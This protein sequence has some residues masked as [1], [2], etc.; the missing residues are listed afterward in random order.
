MAKT[1]YFDFIGSVYEF[2]PDSD[3]KILLETWIGYEQ[4]FASVYQKFLEADLNI[5]IRDLQ[6]YATERWINFAFDDSNFIPRQAFLTSTQDISYGIN[7]TNRYLLRF[8]VD[9]GAAFEVDIRGKDRLSTKIEEIVKKINLVAGF[10]FCRAIYD[11]SILQVSSQTIGPASKVEIL[12]TSDMSKNA[13]E[14]TFGLDPDSEDIP[15]LYPKY[16]FAFSLPEKNIVSIPKLQTAIHDEK[17]ETSLF[18]T[19]DYSIDRDLAFVEFKKMPPVSLWAKRV[20]YDTETPWNNFGFLMGIYQKNDSSYLQVLQGL[21]Y[22]FWTGPRPENIRTALYLLFGLPVSKDEGVV[23]SISS[24]E[25]VVASSVSG[26]LMSY[27]I[28]S[29]LV[30]IV[31]VGQ[32]VNKFEPLVNGIDIFDNVNYPGFIETEVGRTGIQRFLLPEATR[33]EGDTDETKALKLI[34]EHTFL[35]QILV[36]SFVDPKINLANVKL[37]LQSIKPLSKS[38]LFQ[39]IVGAFRDKIVFKEIVGYDVNIDVTPNLDSNQTTFAESSVLS[40]YETVDMPELNLDSDGVLFGDVLDV[41]VLK[42][43]LPI[44]AF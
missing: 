26:A 28:P 37:F 13:C 30:P 32:K 19:T 1:N 11:N 6:P 3:K 25:I 8:R 18:E 23:T 44:D 24:T 34:E 14:I 7:T 39:V 38:F 29:E 21:W 17:S 33:G 22:A 10:E 41:I 4:V 27:V 5:A 31:A 12:A 36:E 2:L 9:D 35:P 42:N 16:P 15:G 43:G 20:M 40:Q